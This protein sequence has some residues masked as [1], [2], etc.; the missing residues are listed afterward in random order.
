MQYGFS[1][2]ET[3]LHP[4]QKRLRLLVLF[5]LLGHPLFWLLWTFGLPQTYENATLR[6]LL[7]LT[8]IGFFMLRQRL[9]QPTFGMR[10]FYG[11]MCWLQ[12]P[13]FFIWM[14]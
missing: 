2:L 6:G 10:V 3:V 13:V 7:A 9:D 4:T 14:Y 12:L 8:G 5:T 11:W 1:D